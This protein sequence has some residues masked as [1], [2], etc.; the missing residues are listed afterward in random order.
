MKIISQSQPD[1]NMYNNSSFASITISNSSTGNNGGLESNGNM[2]SMIAKRNFYRHKS[3]ND[4]FEKA[5]NLETFTYEKVS[6]N[7]IKTSKISKS[8]NS[9]I[10]NFIPQYGPLNSQAYIT[11]PMDLIGISNAIEVF[12]VDYYKGNNL[13]KAAILGIASS[14]GTV[15]EHTKLVCDRLDGAT[16]DDIRHINIAGYPFILAKMVQD[17]GEVDYAVSFIAYKNGNTYTID[18]RWDLETY[19]P[20]GNHAVINFQVWSVSERYTVQLIESIINLINSNGYSVNILNKYP[21]TIPMVYVRNGYYKS[22]NLYLEIKNNAEASALFFNGNVAYVEDGNRYDFSNLKLITNNNISQITVPTNGIF[23]IGFSMINNAMGGRDILYYA[24]GP[25]G[26]DY[27]ETGATISDFSISSQIPTS[28]PNEYELGRNV[29]A[30]GSVKDY[31]SVF[32]VLKVGNKPVDISDYNGIKFSAIGSG[33][34]DVVVSKKSISQWNMQY[35]TTINLSYSMTDYYIPF[36]QLVNNMGQHNFTAQ[37]V[38]TVTFVKKGNNTGFQ[39][40]TLSIKNLRFTGNTITVEDI[41]KETQNSSIHVNPNP[42]NKQTQINFNISESS[43][44]KISILNTEGK[45]IETISS[46]FYQEG[47]YSIDFTAKDLKQGIYIIKLQTDKE[48]RFSKV[49]LLN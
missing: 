8:T 16:L 31:V 37:D 40:F 41:K 42:F 19:Q 13:R 1:F 24:D 43:H 20:T 6:N 29:Y 46:D 48:T 39:S 17:N 32:R 38:V 11:T 35:K 2:A 3:S 33:A 21:P 45:E 23:D 25:W 27:E 7:K 9:E 5:D 44:V 36:S 18:N 15:Y 49:V 30:E 26:I 12:S 22:G 34:F 28:E 10:I 4:R 47:S 14:A